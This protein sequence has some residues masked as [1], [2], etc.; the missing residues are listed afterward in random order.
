NIAKR[1]AVKSIIHF[2]FGRIP[3][4]IESKNWEYK[5]LMRVIRLAD[6]VIVIDQKSYDALKNEGFNNIELFPN[7]VTPE[8]HQI[9]ERNPNIKRDTRKI[10]F[11]GHVK[12]TKGVFELIEACKQIE[13]VSVKLIG[14]V[15]DEMRAV[16][17]NKINETDS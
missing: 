13:N 8:I 2:R 4:L 17:L 9:I 15:T 5:L 1:K 16:L 11:A 3:E 7:P 14:K 6:V 10:L 12:E